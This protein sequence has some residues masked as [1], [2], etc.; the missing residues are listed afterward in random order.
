MEDGIREFLE[1]ARG[2]PLRGEIAR[3]PARVARAWAEDLLSG[4]REEVASILSPLR[5][6]RSRDLVAVRGIEFVSTCA[7]HLLPFHGVAHLAYLP[8]GRITGISRL[9][10]LVRCLTRR[11]QIQ[12]E[13]TRQ[14]VDAL[15]R[16]LAPR[17]AA[18]VIEATH[19][20]MISRGNKGST[21]LVV[22]AAFSGC[23]E[24][25][26]SR[27]GQILALLRGDPRPPRRR[28]RR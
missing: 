26:P 17:G 7:H 8:D 25:E 11:L 13:L 15:D 18:C 6:E 28:P 5:S 24:R 4:Y 16:H 22:T 12:E 10:K 9:P 1:G 23:L 20:C 14:I 21:G 3:T 19:L 2:G 27:R